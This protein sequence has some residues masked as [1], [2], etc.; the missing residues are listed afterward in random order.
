MILEAR[1]SARL[2]AEGMVNAIV[3]VSWWY[4][5]SMLR[6]KVFPMAWNWPCSHCAAFCTS[7]C[8]TTIKSTG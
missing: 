1:I 2:T 6:S 5:T 4:L 8:T 7:A 3:S